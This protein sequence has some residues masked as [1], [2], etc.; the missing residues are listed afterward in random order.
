MA[1]QSTEH[2]FITPRHEPQ[3]LADE[4]SHRGRSE[5]T[6][7][8]QGS[9]GSHHS[10]T[11]CRSTADT[12]GR[13]WFRRFGT[14][15]AR[16]SRVLHTRAWRGLLLGSGSAIGALAWSGHLAAVPISLLIFLVLGFQQTRTRALA[17]MVSYYAGATWQ[18]IPAAAAFFGHHASA[19]HGILLWVGTSLLLGLAWFPLWSQKR[20]TRLYTIPMAICL[21]A[22]PPFGLIGVASPLTAAGIL[23]PGMAWFGLLLT[24]LICGLLASYPIWSL[25]ATII[26][27]LPAQLLY[28]APEP[29]SDWQA[30]STRFGGVGLDTP[31]PVA[32]YAVAQ[33][34]QQT[35][36]SSPARVIIFPETVVSNWNKATDAFWGRTLDR[37]T[38]EG[39]TI[40]VGANVSDEDTPHYFNAIVIRGLHRQRD[41]LQRIPIPIAMWAPYSER[42]VPLRLDGAGTLDIAG[43]RAAVLICYEHLLV[44]PV[45]TSFAQ[46]PTILVGIAN[47]YWARETTIAAIQYVSLTGWA[48]L[49][50]VPMLLAEN[51]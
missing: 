19:V 15:C 33:S 31:N 42:G 23:F 6:T 36:L 27:S 8:P 30:V 26:F 44:W 39:K 37:L 13:S 34:I 21:V 5:S 50:H 11:P 45:I 48:R 43:R 49:F 12:S 24:L 40:L 3:T 2:S 17:L 18:L 1:S 47:D 51:T 41:F 22:V 14:I 16:C 29:P 10:T 38:R 28:R 4:R 9:C 35:A 7:S 46:H 20:D 25:V 32:E